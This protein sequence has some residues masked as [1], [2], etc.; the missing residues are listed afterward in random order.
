MPSES[1]T[2]F[3]SYCREDS[4]FALKL[5]ED[6]KAAGANVWIDQLDIEY[7]EAW[8]RAVEDALERSPRMVVLLSPGAVRS[9]NVQNEIS[10]ALRKRKKVLP[11]LYLDCEI[12]LQLELINYIDFRSDYARG[13]KILLRAF[14]VEQPASSQSAATSAVIAEQV[15]AVVDAQRAA[16]QARIEEEERDRKAAAERARGCRF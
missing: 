13:L 6:L 16:E 14:G 4:D 7:G 5:A 9:D 3:F 2:A 15:V 1:Q 8:T 11:A 10:R 12:P